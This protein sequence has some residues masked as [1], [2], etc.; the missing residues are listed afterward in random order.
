MKRMGN[1]KSNLGLRYFWGVCFYK[2]L[3]AVAVEYFK[4]C[5]C[6]AQ[7]TIFFYMFHGFLFDLCIGG[8]MLCTL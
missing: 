3:V 4:F 8:L 7:N 1:G 2:S 6:C 5:R